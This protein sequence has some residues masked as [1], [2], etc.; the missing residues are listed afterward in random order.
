MVCALTSGRSTSTPCCSM[1]AVIMKMMSRTS[2]TSTSG[3][4]LISAS[5]VPGV[6]LPPIAMALP[7]QEMAL[8]D[9]EEIAG[10]ALHLRRQYADPAHEVV[11]RH[12]RRHGGH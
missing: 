1:G 5:I 11:V 4:T 9:V 3:V 12:D 7:L 8:D 6:W 2:M 10:E